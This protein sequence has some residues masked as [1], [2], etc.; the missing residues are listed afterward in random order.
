[1]YVVFRVLTALL[2]LLHKAF[3]MLDSETLAREE[4]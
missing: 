1:M 3:S 2:L 4:N